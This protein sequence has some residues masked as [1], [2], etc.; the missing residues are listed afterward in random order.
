MVQYDRTI[1]L[2]I[3]IDTV[4][5]ISRFSDFALYLEDY[6]M[7]EHYYLGLCISMTRSLTSK[8]M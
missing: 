2:K 3:K 8:Q 7:Y 5:Y 6:L 1:N 4:T